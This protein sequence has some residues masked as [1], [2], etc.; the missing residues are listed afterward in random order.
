MTKFC[1]IVLSLKTTTNLIMLAILSG[2]ILFLFALHCFIRYE[3]SGRLL[4]L[5]SGPQEYPIIGNLHHLQMND[6]KEY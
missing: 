6:S 5:I 3:R 1:E 4:S 2:L